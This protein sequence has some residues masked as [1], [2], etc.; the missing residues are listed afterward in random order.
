MA[1]S[2]YSFAG[3]SGFSGFSGYSGINQTLVTFTAANTFTTGQAIYKTSGG[4]ALAQANS[5]NTSDIIG[6]VISASSTQFTYV[7][8]GY[9]TGFTGLTDG[10]QYYLSDI[11]AGLV[12]TT[13]PT[14]GGSVIKPVM[15][16][17]GTTA[18]QIVEYPGALIGSSNNGTSGYYAKWTSTQS[19]GNGILSDNGA[20]LTVTGNLSATGSIIGGGVAYSKVLFTSLFFG[21]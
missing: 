19:I 11:T 21:R 13:M 17:I 4:Y 9:T 1:N 8:N 14:A 10:A 16:A 7:A 12:T 20:T 18:A 5:V 2:A 15:I 3:I 6:V